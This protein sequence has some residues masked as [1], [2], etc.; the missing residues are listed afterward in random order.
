MR[1]TILG[2]TDI[3]REKDGNFGKIYDIR[4]ERLGDFFS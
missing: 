2:Q 4:A 1:A 3:E